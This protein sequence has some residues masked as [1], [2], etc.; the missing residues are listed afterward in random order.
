MLQV[1]EIP[2]GLV[3]AVPIWIGLATVLLGL[4][5]VVATAL[6]ATP[7][8]RALAARSPLLARMP[9]APWVPV[10]KMRLAT[11]AV[12]AIGGLW[13]V[14]TG[15]RFLTTSTTFERR[16]VI[17][18][19]LTGEEDRLAWSQVRRFEIEELALSRGRANYLVLYNLNGDYVPVGISGLPA[20]D[21]LR[22]QRFAAERI[23]R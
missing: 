13:L 12:A 7:A 9:M 16:G 3:L 8:G 18:T 15:V 19:G 10:A 22:L 1:S 17:V 5:L 20:E 2:E 4:G 6:A 21:S 11:L 14:Y 23:K